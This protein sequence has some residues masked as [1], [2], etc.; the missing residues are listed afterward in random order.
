MQ[1]T[2]AAGTLFWNTFF[3]TYAKNLDIS[4][5]MYKVSSNEKLQNKT[6]NLVVK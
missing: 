2:S 1:V 4:E 5:L 6:L 3:N